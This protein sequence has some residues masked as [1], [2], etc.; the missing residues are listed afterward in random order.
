MG[1][2]RR[3]LA[4]A[5]ALV[6]ALAAPAR[7]QSG[8]LPEIDLQTRAKDVRVAPGASGNRVLVPTDEGEASLTPEEY[9]AALAE[10]QERQRNAGWVY[11]VFNITKP[12]G[13]LWVSIGFLGQ[14]LFTLRMLLQWLASEKHKRSVVP[15]G[16]WWG[17]LFGGLMLFVYFCWRKDAVGIVGQSTG[18]FIYARNLRLIYRDHPQGAPA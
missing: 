2:E 1:V 9:V 18:V 11:V 7:A 17:S 14:A 10:A 5:G 4:L 6:F 3:L 16:F 8:A 12:I 15:V 13:F